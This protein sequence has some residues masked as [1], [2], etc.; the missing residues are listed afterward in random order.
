MD[1]APLLDR[2]RRHVALPQPAAKKSSARFI[3]VLPPPAEL[4]SLVPQLLS[5]L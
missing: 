5:C 2:L 3:P 1:E 4:E